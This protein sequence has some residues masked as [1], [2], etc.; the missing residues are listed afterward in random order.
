M[1]KV[2]EA[3]EAACFS[4]TSTESYTSLATRREAE[5]RQ[6]ESRSFAPHAQTKRA[7]N[8]TARDRRETEGRDDDGVGRF[9]GAFCL[10]TA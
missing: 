2:N 6:V 8:V 4:N 5:P 9:R 10:H 3:Q 7:A 1:H